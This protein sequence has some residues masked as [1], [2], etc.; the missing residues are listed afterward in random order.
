M[1]SDSSDTKADAS[2]GR[3]PLSLA[4]SRSIAILGAAWTVGFAGLLHWQLTAAPGV[5]YASRVRPEGFRPVA[6]A[7]LA[8]AWVWAFVSVQNRDRGVFR[9]GH[10]RLQLLV[11][12]IALLTISAHAFLFWLPVIRG[13]DGLVVFGR[14]QA[15]STPV[16]AILYCVGFSAMSLVVEHASAR[17][18]APKTSGLS[19]GSLLAILAAFLFL[20]VTVNALSVP[21][22][23]RALFFGGG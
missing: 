16:Q 22:V 5:E 10:E 8:L 21:I 2:H 13:V 9:E 3:G 4:T 14:I 6:I 11:T 19:I 20:L 1:S 15:L 23:G 7:T 17:I 18:L 12:P